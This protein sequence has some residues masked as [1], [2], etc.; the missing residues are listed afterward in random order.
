MMFKIGG[1]VGGGVWK[2]VY[3]IVNYGCNFCLKWLKV[4]FLFKI[5]LII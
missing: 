3:G 5:F 1:V 2:Y 4:G